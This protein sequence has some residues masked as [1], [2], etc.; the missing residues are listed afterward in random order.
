M[1][2][3]YWQCKC[4]NLLITVCIFV[5]PA[6]ALHYLCVLCSYVT[7]MQGSIISLHETKPIGRGEGGA[8][9]VHDDL[10]QHVMCAIN[11]GFSAATGVR[12]GHRGCS[13]WRMSDIAAAAICDHL[14][15]VIDDN[16]VHKCSN[17][18]RFAQQELQKCGL[19]AKLNITV[20]TILSCLLITVP[21]NI[22]ELC[23]K[24]SKRQLSIEAKHYYYPLATRAEVPLAWQWFDS[25]I[26]LPF[27]LDVSEQN[28]KYMLTALGEECT[29][30]QNL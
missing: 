27:H 13:N 22:D 19:S 5:T 6:N 8:V 21:G 16:W 29:A 24:L 18:A 7:V 15:T 17:L 4:I 28:I 1:H 12:L 9:V 2:T 10:Q 25:T 20:P 30:L 11:F 23:T 26:C 3:R 14:D